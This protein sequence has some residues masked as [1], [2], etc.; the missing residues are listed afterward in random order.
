VTKES[1][2]MKDIHKVRERF[3]HQTKG[4]SRG[5]ILRLIKEDSKE[6][7]Q[8]LEVIEADPNL[9]VRKKYSIPPLDS[10]EEIHLIRERGSKYGSGNK[11]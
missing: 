11:K 8:K 4:K 1:R 9:V 10:T 5:D 6:V 3:Y 2:I 7:K